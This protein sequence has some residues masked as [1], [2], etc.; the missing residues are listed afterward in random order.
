MGFFKDM[1][2]Q[3]AR[4]GVKKPSIS[5][6]EALWD[7]R[8]RAL[9][10]TLGKADDGVFHS[11]VPLNMGGGADVL[12]FGDALP[13]CVVYCTADLTGDPSV[14]QAGSGEGFEL[15]M[16]CRADDGAMRE[17]APSILSKLAPYTLRAS[18]AAGHSMNIGEV[19]ST[20]ISG[21]VFSEW[22]RARAPFEFGGRRY[23]LLLCTGLTPEETAYAEQHGGPALLERLKAAGV[24][25]KTIAGRASCV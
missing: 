16:C 10:R 14:E 20:G 5:E 9:E 7:E 8:Q 6:W 17:I 25:P 1:L 19:G 15:V 23:G 21:L 13:G 24:M 3:W 11:P 12:A 22:T 4:L 2:A 18:V